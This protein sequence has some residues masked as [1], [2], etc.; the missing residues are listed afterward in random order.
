MTNPILELQNATVAFGDD[1]ILKDVSMK[2]YPHETIVLIGLSGSGKSVLL[3]TLAG[4]YEPSQGHSLCFG[5]PWDSLSLIDRHDLAQKIGV[6]FQKGALFD[7]LSGFENVAYPLREHTHQSE[8]QIEQRVLEC[9]RA[10]DLEKAKD[11]APHEMSGG[12][13]QRLGIARAIALNPEILFLD[14]PTAGLD[15]INSDNM[16]D[17]I[18]KLKNDLNTTLIV[19]THDLSRAFQFAGRIFFVGSKAVLETGGADETKKSTDPRVQQYLQGKLTG[20]LT[21]GSEL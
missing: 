4:L 16:A 18:L 9:L 13:R 20:P 2:V 6:Q 21:D 5:H 14:D 1:I 10:V 8:A 7:D 15:P 12:M 17:L 19:V 3:K 11:L